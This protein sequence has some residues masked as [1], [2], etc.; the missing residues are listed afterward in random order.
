[1]QHAEPGRLHDDAGTDGAR[2]GDALEDGDV[3]AG[4]RQVHGRR[5][6]GSAGANHGDIEATHG[7]N[8]QAVQEETENSLIS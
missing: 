7:K 3:M 8:L 4:A 5:R 6:A 1:V 2:V